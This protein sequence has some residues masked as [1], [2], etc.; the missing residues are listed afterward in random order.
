[1]VD[2]RSEDRFPIKLSGSC[3][4]R[5]GRRSSAEISELSM[6]GCKVRTSPILFEKDATLWVRLGPRGGLE[7]AIKWHRGDLAGL[8]WINPLHP[9]ILEHIYTWHAEDKQTEGAL[10]DDGS[11]EPQPVLRRAC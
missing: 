11:D 5:R 4:D 9:A 6:H 10:A 8:R 1:M 3:R 7:A 2:E